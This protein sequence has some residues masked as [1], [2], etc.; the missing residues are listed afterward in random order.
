MKYFMSPDNEL[1]AYE[2]D[3]SQDSIIP[4]D[5]IPATD[6]QIQWV[7]NPPLTIE[8]QIIKIEL[9]ITQRRIRESVLNIDNGWLQQQNDAIAQLRASL[10]KQ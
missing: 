8:Q 5:F 1:F 7:I 3:G 10:S 6:E 2:S 4:V 9:T